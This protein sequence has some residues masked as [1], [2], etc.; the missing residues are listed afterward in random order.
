MGLLSVNKHEQNIYIAR[1]YSQIR[2]D[3]QTV[4]VLRE[5]ISSGNFWV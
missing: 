5:N 2:R 3:K 4:P 1:W